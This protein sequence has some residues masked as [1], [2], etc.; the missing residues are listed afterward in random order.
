[1]RQDNE[2]IHLINC[3]KSWEQSPSPSINMAWNHPIFLVRSN[4]TD[5]SHM[6]TRCVAFGGTQ[7]C[8][9]SKHVLTFSDT[10]KRIVYERKFY[11]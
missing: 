2:L 11:L 8:N 5:S 6:I 4:M 3:D 1:M 10:Q 7:K 9:S